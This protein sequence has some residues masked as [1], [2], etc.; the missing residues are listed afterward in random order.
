MPRQGG[1]NGRTQF[2]VFLLVFLRGG[3]VARGQGKLSVV[4]PL[5]RSEGLFKHLYISI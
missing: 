5:W 1:S 3:G 2:F 4:F